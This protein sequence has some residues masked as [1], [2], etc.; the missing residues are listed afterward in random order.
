MV[1]LNSPLDGL[2]SAQTAFDQA[3]SNIASPPSV[4]SSG[5]TSGDTPDSQDQVSLSDAA[6]AMIQAGNDYQANLKALEV[7]NDMQKSLL[8]IL[9]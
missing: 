9:A 1:A 6:V 7:T 3:A 2:A 8:N 4:V 5:D